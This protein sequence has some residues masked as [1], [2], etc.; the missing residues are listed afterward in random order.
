MT[1]AGP[2][3]VA[4]FLLGASGPAHAGTG[5]PE[6]PQ[7]KVDRV[8]AWNPGRWRILVTALG[9]GGQP[10]PIL[11]H[12]LDV[13]LAPGHEAVNPL[14]A[15]PLTRFEGDVPAKGFSGKIRPIGKSDVAQAVVIVVAS[16]ADVAP[17]VREVLSQAIQTLLKGLRKDARVT[18]LLYG[19]T[20]QVLWSPDGQR[21]EWQDFNEYQN[22]LGRLRREAAGERADG[23]VL[24]CGGLAEQP[25]TVQGWIRVLPPG[26]GLFPRLFGIREAEEV[27]REAESRGHSM[28]ERR[29]TDESFEPFATGAV[30]AAARLLMAGSE[31][32]AE[33]LILLLSDGRDGY[34]RVSGLVSDHIGRD[35]ACTEKAKSCAARAGEGWA[36]RSDPGL[37]RGTP[38][39]DHE[40]GSPEC[41]RE[42]LECAIPRVATALRRR[43]DVV[44]EYLVMLVQRLRAA[45]VRVQA[46]ALPGTDEV[47]ARR[48]QALSLKTGGTFR[49][50]GN[51]A[52]LAKDTPQALADEMKFQVVVVPPVGLDPGRE[53]SLAVALAGP[54]RVT[55]APYRFW[56]GSRVFFFERPLARARRY[57]ISKLGHGIG[58]PVFWAAVVVGGLMAIAFVWMMGK[59]IVGLAK[60]LVKKGGGKVPKAPKAP[61][62]V[63]TLKRP[64][65]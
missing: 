30:E 31:P 43:E 22:C 39:D 21:G 33:R 35:R 41:T 52:R 27:R 26:Q 63:P 59:G 3:V 9:E 1:R 53:Y 25:D 13:Y 36:D 60:R 15:S 20:I 34:L 5:D 17:D 54:E 4:T 46:I 57:V 29:R 11:D 6:W 62:K 56:T 37:G 8:D 16:H 65:K 49:S 38:A 2:I 14:G 47:G 45:G 55:S 40:G 58:P 12:G 44:R 61:G 42:V 24:P 32:E 10:I 18:V 50:A 48:L 23:T 7:V 28:L 64:G 51:V 19:D